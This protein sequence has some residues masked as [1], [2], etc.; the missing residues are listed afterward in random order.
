MIQKKV[1]VSKFS[2]IFDELKHISLLIIL[3]YYI[4]DKTLNIIKSLIIMKSY[5]E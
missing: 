3:L 4:F 2:N 1:K 5:F